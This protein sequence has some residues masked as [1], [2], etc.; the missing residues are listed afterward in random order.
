MTCPKTANATPPTTAATVSIEWL[1]P[2]HIPALLTLLD[3]V[4]GGCFCNFWHF[5]ADDYAWQLRCGSDADKNRRATATRLDDT[6]ALGIVALARQRQEALTAIGWLSLLAAPQ[7]HKLHQRRVYR[8]LPT[9]RNAGADVW[10]VG[11]AVVAPA[12]RGQ[13]LW[14]RMLRRAI[15]IARVKNIVAIEAF[16]RKSEET[17]R[18]EEMW[19]GPYSDYRALGFAHVDGPEGYPVMRLELAPKRLFDTC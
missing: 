7:M 13:H 2:A 6:N 3:H 11:C 4:S 5:A 19:M 16:P 18:P 8:T 14:R 17:L 10:R 15:A 12:W 1:T 9:L